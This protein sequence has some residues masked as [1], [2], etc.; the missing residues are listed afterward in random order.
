MSVELK[1]SDCPVILR[2]VRTHFD[3]VRN[4]WVLLAPERVLKLDD[5]ARGSPAAWWKPDDCADA[6]DSAPES[7]DGN[8]GRADASL[9][10][11]LSLLL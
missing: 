10:A 9:S 11:G 2:G 1:D 4:V 5:V 3:N 7:A 8:A 6:S